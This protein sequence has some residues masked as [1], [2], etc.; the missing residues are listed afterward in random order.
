MLKLFSRF[1]Y[2]SIARRLAFYI[3]GAGLVFAF[4][5][6]GGRLIWFFHQQLPQIK[7]HVKSESELHLDAIQ[8]AINLQD[9]GLLTSH[10]ARLSAQDSV[11][12]IELNWIDTD[13]LERQQRYPR[14]QQQ[15]NT[16]LTIE[17]NAQTQPNI[18]NVQFDLDLSGL[19]QTLWYELVMSLLFIAIQAAVIGFL[20][21]RITNIVFSKH[22]RAICHY[23]QNLQI[24]RLNQPFTLD[25]LTQGQVSD[26]LDQVAAAI[27][28]MRRQLLQDVNTRQMMEM[29]LLAVKEEKLKSKRKQ[30]A[31]EAANKAKSQFIATVSHE[32]RTP[33]NG[34]IG[35]IDL[36]GQ[37]NLNSTQK[38]Y[39]DIV[40]RSGKSLMAVM[41][42]ILDY[43][44][45]EANSMTLERHA[46]DLEELL[47]DCVQLFAATTSHNNIELLSSICP[48]T[49]RHILGDP[50][51]LRQV[52]MNLLSNAFKFTHEGHVHISITTQ[53]GDNADK[54][55]LHF[56]ISDTGIGIDEVTQTQLFSAFNQGDNSTTRRFGGTGLGLAIARKLVGLMGGEMGL[57]STPNK[58]STFWF[59][60]YFERSQI[61]PEPIAIL[62]GTKIL[63]VHDN[64]LLNETLSQYCQQ[65]SVHCTS[66]PNGKEVLALLQTPAVLRKYDALLINSELSDMTG[67][68]LSNAIHSRLR[69]PNPRTILLTNQIEQQHE[70]SS[71]ELL[72]LGRPITS[73]KLKH[74]LVNLTLSDKDKP[75][76]PA[77][78]REYPNL[79]VLIAEDNPVNQL[80]TEGLLNKLKVQPDIAE[81]GQK[82][83]EKV[84]AKGDYDVIFM[85]C[86]MPEMDGFEASRR[87][88]DWELQEHHQH[89]RIIALTAH[90]EGEHRREVFASGMDY[91]LS[92][93]VTLTDICEALGALGVHNLRQAAS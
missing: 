63:I 45:I 93:P 73:R 85:D 78:V 50:L 27:N 79:K 8:I 41:N 62:P 19:Y 51:R 30:L 21:L 17:P 54:P 6:L 11:R 26:E 32:I 22:L 31:A 65:W 82:A 60:A 1:F 80:V 43:S 4:I 88:R 20:V 35:M 24:D 29:T 72:Y 81:N 91:Y 92:K 3:I 5:V 9:P 70:Q 28:R 56:A 71:D 66:L 48:N 90:V 39:M 87:I 23:T 75:H 46:F 42:D 53:P 55:C 57:H 16:E 18:K 76:S 47:D 15:F 49:P 64:P 14:S 12:G 36:L 2:R 37:T 34:I 67:I 86:E 40:Q 83:L 84:I 58:G 77:L 61:T 33:M 7:Q 69:S 25:R 13:G 74:L 38:H 10:L 68:E 89:T 59:T 52:I 44:L